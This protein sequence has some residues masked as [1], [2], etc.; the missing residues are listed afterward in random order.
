MSVTRGYLGRELFCAIFYFPSPFAWLE[1]LSVSWWAKRDRRERFISRFITYI[2]IFLRPISIRMSCKLFLQKHEE[3]FFL[4]LFE[5]FSEEHDVKI[6]SL[7][8]GSLY[9]RGRSKLERH[10]RGTCIIGLFREVF[11]A[12]TLTPLRL[13]QHVVSI[14]VRYVCRCICP[15]CMHLSEGKKINKNYPTVY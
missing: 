11:S 4:A 5:V 15:V 9:A 2:S 8:E 1:R 6:G 3:W 12:H 10:A 14:Y 7:L 13:R